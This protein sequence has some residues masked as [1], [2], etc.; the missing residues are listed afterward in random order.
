VAGSPRCWLLLGTQY[1]LVERFADVL[2]HVLIGGV[3]LVV[4]TL[5]VRRLRTKRSATV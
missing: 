3:V 2:D 1:R 5:V 4:V